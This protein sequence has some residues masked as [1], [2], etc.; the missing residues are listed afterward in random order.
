MKTS[1]DSIVV[2]IG[3]SSLATADY[4][5][6]AYNLY[7]ANKKRKFF[8]VSA[9]GVDSAKSNIKSAKNNI[10]YKLTDLLISLANRYEMEHYG[11]KAVAAEA[12]G[13]EAFDK[14]SLE[15]LVIN[16]F[17]E[18]GA[19]HD[20][21]NPVREKLLD[22]LNNFSSSDPRQHSANVQMLGEVFS[23]ETLYQL[24]KRNGV[25]N[26]KKLSAADFLVVNG[27][28]PLDG[29]VYLDNTLDNLRRWKA[30][31]DFDP[32][33]VYIIDGYNGR[34]VDG[35]VSL[36][37]RD[38]T[39]KTQILLAIGLCIQYCE[40]ISDVEHIFSVNPN[41]VQ[42]PRPIEYITIQE[43]IELSA[44]GGGKVFQASA[45]ALM[46]QAGIY[47]TID[48]KA[49]SNADKT[50]TL[51]V[52]TRNHYET[53][54]VGIGLREAVT[55]ITI[56]DPTM[57]DT[58]GYV[59][60]VLEQIAQMNINLLHIRSGENQISLYIADDSYKGKFKPNEIV[61]QI[62]S[63]TGINCNSIEVGYNESILGVI[64]EG[65]DARLQHK[66]QGVLLDNNIRMLPYVDSS[67]V[68]AYFVV[69]RDDVAKAANVLYDAFFKR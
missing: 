29:V 39:N 8:V 25:E 27:G 58:P 64:G 61:N 44:R 14:N 59:A 47:P 69:H 23:Q 62:A 12:K 38:G 50:G 30:S 36:L 53:P 22:A 46:Q 37:A 28:N 19:L 31:N 60:K 16:K 5:Q 49:Y 51:I 35:R 48:V 7:H 63:N 57:A 1:I 52:S 26:V 9:P 21:V 4:F 55:N 54:L 18:F 41:L 56:T 66:I 2:K 3:G 20:P 33:C 6:Q 42:N 65:I 15:S 11:N 40:N 45:L 32:E 13:L 17:G 34:T 43:Q 10:K 68:S 24:F 67:N